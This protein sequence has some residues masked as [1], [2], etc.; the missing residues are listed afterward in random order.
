MLLQKLQSRFARTLFSLPPAVLRRLARQ[1]KVVEG[2]ALHPAFQVLFAIGEKANQ[3]PLEELGLE[4]ARRQYEFF[5]EEVMAVPEPPAPR[6]RD[7]RVEGVPVRIHHPAPGRA[8]PL[9]VYFHGGGWVVGSLRTHEALCRRLSRVSG[10]AVAAVDYR[11]APE[12][13]FPA[14]V[15]DCLASVHGLRDA[16][17]RY[18]LLPDRVALA[19]DSAGGNLAAVVGQALGRAGEPA[20]FQLLYYPGTDAV[21]DRPSKT[22]FGKGYGLD[23]STM[24]WMV[25]SYAGGVDRNDPRLSPMH[26]DLAQSPP[27]RLVVGHFDPLR[28]E[29]LAFAA[30]LEEAGVEVESILCQDLPHTFVHA[31][32]LARVRAILD[33]DAL[34]LRAV[35]HA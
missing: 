10:C 16:A 1:P 32:R 11:L 19:G 31:T 28:D 18:E 30:A 12:H 4:A 3:P 20:R 6:T 33:A 22:L 15:D 26:G 34:R 25:G 13:P 24:D 17:D 14:A 23:R 29:S 27:T 8:V 2:E 5:V 21:H 35:L 9:V 7:L